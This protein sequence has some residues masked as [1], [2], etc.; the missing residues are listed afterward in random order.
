MNPLTLEWVEEAEGDYD[1]A[2]REARARKRPNYDAACFHAQQ[3]AE[4]YLKAIL[5]EANVPFG[6]TPNLVGLLDLVLPADASWEPL[7]TTLQT[8]TGSPSMF[9]TPVHVRTNAWHV[10]LWPCVRTY[11]EKRAPVWSSSLEP[12]PGMVH[13]T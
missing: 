8:L 5:Q 2:Q 10:M 7:R 4:K 6:K 1:T 11:A 3:C 9:D 12:C 13:G